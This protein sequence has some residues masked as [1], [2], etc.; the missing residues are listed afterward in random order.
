MACHSRAVVLHTLHIGKRDTILCPYL[1]NYS[2]LYSLLVTYPGSLLF[3]LPLYSSRPSSSDAASVVSLALSRSMNAC[4]HH[5][6]PI[7]AL[8][9]LSV[10]SQIYRSDLVAIYCAAMFFLWWMYASIL[11]NPASTL[12][13]SAEL[14]SHFSS[15]RCC[16]IRLVNCRA[17][18]SWKLLRIQPM[19]G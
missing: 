4:S 5:R 9:V 8:F 2:T 11:S 6:I 7:R 16:G 1:V 19:W 14:Y 10:T 17:T 12:V 15:C 13:A 18:W 3:Y